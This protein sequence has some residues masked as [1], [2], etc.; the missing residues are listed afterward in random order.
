MAPREE[1]GSSVTG[2]SARCILGAP[3]HSEGSAHPEDDSLSTPRLWA[4]HADVIL[5]NCRGRPRQ[6]TRIALNAV[7]GMIS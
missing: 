7:T 3:P 1:P 5:H 6:M 4:R 2:E